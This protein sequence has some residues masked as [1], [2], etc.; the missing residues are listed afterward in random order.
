MLVADLVATCA[1]AD[2]DA[3]SGQC[4]HVVWVA[5]QAFGFPPLTAA[6]GTVISAAIGSCWA[7]GFMVRVIR[8]TVGV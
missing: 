5:Q 2:V 8:K 6:E 1:E 7:I 3:V 4:A